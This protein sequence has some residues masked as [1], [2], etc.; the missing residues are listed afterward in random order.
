[1]IETGQDQNNA[2]RSLA[3]IMFSDIVGFT[4]LMGES[5]EKALRNRRL[6]REIHQQKIEAA[7]GTWIKEM[8]DGTMASFANINDALRAAI[9]IRK[10]C[11]QE[12]GVELK[13]GI[14][15]AEVTYE[16]NDVFGE[17]VNMASRLE[18][19]AFG[20]GIL[21]SEPVHNDIKSKT[22]FKAAFIGETTLKNVAGRH[23]I[24][25]VLDRD[26]VKPTI[27]IIPERKRSSTFGI[28]SLLL[29][30]AAISYWIVKPLLFNKVNN[31][32]SIAVLPFQNPSDDES[33]KYYGIGLAN[34]IRSRLS[35]SRQFEFVSSMQAT[36]GYTTSDSPAKIGEEL[37]VKYIL[38]GIYQVS[39]ERIKVDV[40]L[41]ETRS[42]GVVWNRSFNEFFADIFE[43]QSE[44]ATKVFNEFSMMDNQDKEV[45]TQN[46]EAYAHF[47]RG[48]ELMNSAQQVKTP[49]GRNLESEEQ[50]SL[51]IQ[52][53][54]SFIDPYVSLVE[55]KAYWIFTHPRLKNSE[56]YASILKEV[57]DLNAYSE[58]HFSG[59]PKYTLIRACIAYYVNRDYDEGQKYFEEVLTHDPE[60]FTAHFLL[61]AIYKRKL[62]QKEA[63]AHLSKASRLDPRLSSVWQEMMIVF[64][65]MGDYA[66][67][68]KAYQHAVILGMD[69]D[70]GTGVFRDQGKTIPGLKE[71]H[72]MRYYLETM[73]YKRD[74]GGMID[75]LDTS[76][77]LEP[78]FS[79]WL[80]AG[81][82]YGLEIQDSVNHYSQFYLDHTD[83]MDP[84]KH[85]LLG[86]KEIAIRNLRASRPMASGS[87]EFMAYCGLKIDEIILLSILGEYGQATELL[88][89]L[90][91]EYPGFGAYGQLFN[92]P[93]MDK[94]KRESPQ[95]VKALNG[96]KFPPKMELKG[97]IKF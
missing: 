44:I 92:D 95:F 75:M 30:L 79:A 39:G 94:I 68:E 38:S 88:L 77:G 89:K 14:H 93:Y 84:Y 2:K 78:V 3:A 13:V 70:G 29:V 52:K 17:G 48:E 80:K 82:Y 31:S 90:N 59:S 20:G 83:G 32:T 55:S 5:E 9:E 19:L 36:M 61:G 81:A 24:Y 65:T 51:A 63:I 45:P 41:V 85:A 54:S 15:F 57:M 1:M 18:A 12:M 4:A 69:A 56:E 72:P 46:M 58:E 11:K 27:K 97:L 10:S 71:D 74:F 40:E 28:A 91:R 53:D 66:A 86:N 33:Q 96:L 62:M 16:D 50:L 7:G 76:K 26:L 37:D 34:E 25:Q 87:K 35:Q 67:A 6:N 49:S 43:L 8:G 21:I 22:E 60:N 73:W 23:K 64:A 42:G 47:L